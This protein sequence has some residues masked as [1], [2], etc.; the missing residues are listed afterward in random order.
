MRK[1]LVW[2]INE[3]NKIKGIKICPGVSIGYSCH[4]STQVLQCLRSICQKKVVTTH[5]SCDCFQMNKN[6]ACALIMLPVSFCPISY[7]VAA[8][9]PIVWHCP[10]LCSDL[11]LSYC[12]A[13]W[14]PV[15]SVSYSYDAVA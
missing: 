11:P 6:I 13:L 9:H 12:M 3:N 4:K 8:L 15:L 5:S 14:C 1:G 2:G 7:I 10:M